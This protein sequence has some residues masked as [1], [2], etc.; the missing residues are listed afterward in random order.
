LDWGG[1]P[2]I[3]RTI[4]TNLDPAMFE[5]TLI[6][7]RTRH[8]SAKTQDFLKKWR[9]RIVE[10][11]ELIRQINPFL[12]II[13]FL[14]LFF[15]FLHRKFDIVH[16][17]TSKA[18]ALGRAAAWCAGT[19]CI[20]HMPHGHNFYGYFSGFSS[21]LLIGAEKLF[22]LVTDR[23]IA[24]T[25]LEKND[26]VRLKVAEEKKIVVIYQG[27]ELVPHTPDDSCP[28]RI[29]E[30]FNI[31]NGQRVVGMISR[32]ESVKD[33]CTFVKAAKII[34]SRLPDTKFILVGEGSL[35][36]QIEDMVFRLGLAD[37]FILTGWLNNSKDV[38]SIFDVMAL[39]S[40]NEAVGMVLIEAQFQNDINKYQASRNEDL[41]QQKMQ[42][43]KAKSIEQSKN[44]EKQKRYTIIDDDKTTTL[45]DCQENRIK[46]I[47]ICKCMTLRI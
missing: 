36:R 23:I 8:P 1:S 5:V 45:P 20:V 13:A 28:S 18:G 31:K 21:S 34:S 19:S 35:R 47:K 40:L 2:D 44:I 12:D 7:G 41:V 6:T 43:E 10:I 17:H 25:N 42:E 22:S 4:C 24:F 27:L 30:Q 16:T 15:L 11:P 46:I 32:L 3:I 29:K 33:P 26:Y 39:C 14:K 37:Q 9:G 38:L